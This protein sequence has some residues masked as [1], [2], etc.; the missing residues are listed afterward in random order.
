ME[1]D[2]WTVERGLEALGECT[3]CVDGYR[4]SRWS[5]AD[6]TGAEEPVGWRMQR[7]QQAGALPVV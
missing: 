7:D 2:E 3:L 5:E 4:G 6:V 1:C